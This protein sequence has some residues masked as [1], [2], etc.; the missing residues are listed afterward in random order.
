MLFYHVR[1]LIDDFMITIWF[2]GEKNIKQDHYITISLFFWF[3]FFA[4]SQTVSLQH[5]FKYTCFYIWK[6][7]VREK[8]TSLIFYE[9]KWL[10][11]VIS[12]THRWDYNEKLICLM[13]FEQNSDYSSGWESSTRILVTI[14]KVGAFR[15]EAGLY[16]TCIFSWDN[17]F[18]F[19]YLF[20][21]EDFFFTSQSILIL[22]FSVLGT[23][24]WGTWGRNYCIKFADEMCFLK[25]SWINQ[26]MLENHPGA[27]L[28]FLPPAPQFMA[29]QLEMQNTAAN[30]P[31]YRD[32]LGPLHCW[33]M[34]APELRLICVC[35]ASTRA[36]ADR[37]WATQMAWKGA[38]V[39]YVWP[40]GTSVSSML[41]GLAANWAKLNV[42]WHHSIVL[43]FE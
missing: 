29:I 41:T 25:L 3:F 15:A 8:C 24:Q 11:L 39:L 14:Q 42:I 9:P 18:L 21:Q 28:S 20:S 38:G 35:P 22:S 1:R 4:F 7:Y 19:M 12:F 6:P 30:V 43:P 34:V 33:P 26:G 31:N 40:K 5:V 36:F 32:V 16:T 2:H 17:G 13:S 37:G 23:T 10:S 27:T